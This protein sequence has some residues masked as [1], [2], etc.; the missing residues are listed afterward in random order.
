MKQTII[1]FLFLERALFKTFKKFI[2]YA[3]ILSKENPLAA[4]QNKSQPK[5]ANSAKQCLV[6]MQQGQVGKW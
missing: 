1:F 2:N 3:H 6:T 5:L 4:R